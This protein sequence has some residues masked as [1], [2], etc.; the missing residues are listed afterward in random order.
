LLKGDLGVYLDGRK[1]ALK[2]TA[3]NFPA[4][5][6]LRTGWGFMQVEFSA[7]VGP[8][9]TGPHKLEVKNRHLSRLSVYLFNAAQPS[10]SLVQIT[11]QKRNKNQ[12]TGEIEFT[13]QPPHKET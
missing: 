13:V 1:I 6:E 12:S 10:S 5:T 3:S 4:L 9:A 2:L 7:A 11:K 8:L